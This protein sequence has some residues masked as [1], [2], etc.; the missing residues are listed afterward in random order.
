MWSFP[1]AINLVFI[2][3][4][5]LVLLLLFLYFTSLY[6]FKR[7]WVITTRSIKLALTS[8]GTKTTDS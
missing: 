3:E 2:K 5:P 4:A 8:L 6:N 1:K 7:N